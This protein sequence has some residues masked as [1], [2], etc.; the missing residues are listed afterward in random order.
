MRRVEKRNATQCD[1]WQCPKARLGGSSERRV[2]T[3]IAEKTTKAK[4]ARQS[5]THPGKI[6]ET[7]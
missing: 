3:R 2:E 4:T 7:V 6:K 1:S 5:T